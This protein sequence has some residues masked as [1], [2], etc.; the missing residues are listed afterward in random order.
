M[1]LVVVLLLLRLLLGLVLQVAVWLSV[2][3]TTAQAGIPL[4]LLRVLLLVVLLLLGPT[5]VTAS[6]PA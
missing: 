2:T 3:S 1:R 4:H 5:L 6:A